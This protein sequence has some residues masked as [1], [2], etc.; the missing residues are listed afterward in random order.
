MKL[1]LTIYNSVASCS[2]IYI[3]DPFSGLVYC[4]INNNL[5]EFLSITLY[6]IV[7]C[8]DPRIQCVGCKTF[9][10][11]ILF[12]NISSD[13]HFC[14]TKYTLTRICVHIL[15]ILTFIFIP[16]TGNILIFGFSLGIKR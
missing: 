13:I 11:Y 15:I 4:S 7:L 12:R 5:T 9:Y 10:L 1:C 16:L 8:P 14:V 3:R 6:D 2:G